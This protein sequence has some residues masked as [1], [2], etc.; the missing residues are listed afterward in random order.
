MHFRKR[1]ASVLCFSLLF[2]GLFF[3]TSCVTSPPIMNTV[4]LTNV[5]FDKLKEFK[6]G[7]SCTTFIFGVIPVGAT[8]ITSA[9]R[10]GRIKKV[11]VLEY[12]SRNYILV[13]QFCLNAYGL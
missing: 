13:S 6:H 11:K 5:D 1:F 7:E 12:E 10:D 4:D 9:V 8:R 3:M 2:S